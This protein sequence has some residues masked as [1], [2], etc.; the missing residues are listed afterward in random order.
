MLRFYGSRFVWVLVLALWVVVAQAQEFR[1]RYVNLDAA[2]PSSF[3]FFIPAAINDG[4]SSMPLARC[5]QG[6]NPPRLLN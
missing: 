5:P 4:G 1:Y 2:V 3:L 6:L